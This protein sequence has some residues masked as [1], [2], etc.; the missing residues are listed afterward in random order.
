MT[1]FG[2]DR[3]TIDDLGV[4]T[5]AENNAS[6]F[7]FYNHVRTIGGKKKLTEL[8]G[9]PSADIKVLSSRRDCIK[10]FH[11]NPIIFNIDR[12]DL[13][14]IEHYLGFGAKVL[15]SNY[16]DAA[17]KSLKYR[18]NPDN[19]YYV[20][21]QGISNLCTLI[22]SLWR[23][24]NELSSKRCPV[25]INKFLNT[26]EEFLLKKDIEN[27]VFPNSDS[28]YFSYFQI[29]RYD[30]FFRRDQLLP[31][32]NL[33]SIVYE[34]D[35]Y[36]SVSQAV[37]I[38]NFSFPEYQATGNVYVDIK[39][40]YHPVIKNAVT[41]NFLI[42]KDKNLFFLTGANMAGKSSFLKALGLAIYLAHI[43]FPVPAA[44]MQTSVFN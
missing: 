9:S 11:E 27:I 18:L 6:V 21:S 8:M 5:E 7:S 32:K 24:Y 3:Q 10:F 13:D 2:I 30:E 31:L 39:G 34:L 41:N 23:I 28:Y 36:I 29:A 33:L 17:L 12:K 38:H 25:Y 43:G 22:R 16:A 42:T 44:S 37:S 14:F 26:L 15:S 20:I 4:F 19:D 40:L 1:S 35:A